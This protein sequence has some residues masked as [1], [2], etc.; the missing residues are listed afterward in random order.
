[1]LL[2][3]NL[4]KYLVQIAI[5]MVIG[6]FAWR[7]CIFGVGVR[8]EA[9]MRKKMF[10][11]SLKLSQRYYSENKTGAIMALYTNDLQT[12]RHYFG[13]GTIMLIDAVFLGILAFYK[14]FKLDLWLTVISV[15]PLLLLA[16]SG[17][18]VGKFMSRKFEERQK[19]FEN[20]SDFTLESFSGISVVKAFVKEAKELLRFRKINKENEEK[21]IEFAR[22]SVILSVSITLIINLVLLIIIGYGGYLVYSSK[23]DGTN[24]FTVGQL[25]EYISYFGT[26]TWPMMAISNLINMNAQAKAS[27]KRVTA[28]LDEKVE[29]KD[30]EIVLTENT[31]SDIV[32]N[33]L[34]FN[35]P[36]SNVKV[37]EDISFKIN[38]GEF[39]GVIGK[40]GSGKTTLVEMLLRVYNI[41][42]NSVFVGGVDIMKYGIKSLRSK[43][44][45]VPQDN[46]LFSTTILD[47][48]AFASEKAD[49]EKVKLAANNA[50]VLSNIEEFTEGFNTVLG[51]RGVTISGGQKQRT[52]IARALYKDPDILILDDSVS[53]CDTKTEA[54]ILENLMNLRKNKTTIITS[55]R[56][57]TV[58][59]LDK[60][61]LL[62][63]GK[64]VAYGTHD[65]LLDKCF[66]YKE[67]YDMQRLEEEVESYEG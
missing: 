49:F 36:D 13:M 59:S 34:S 40:T 67:M 28:L 15:I 65:E 63:D 23:I 21:N 14:M 51:E 31:S 1:M 26:L 10:E 60:I 9:D 47:N 37:L 24:S 5:I 53:A 54:T 17:G 42:N 46:F 3:K 57:S 45:Y 18:I 41:K 12:I 39:V 30:D 22:Y 25:Q 52:S 29:I 11:K 27:L 61:L 38:E 32:F 48:I 50:D 58:M 44:G 66:E 35:Y 62:D 8:I 6:R 19:A 64:I 43:I 33:N 20:M 56:I 7:I 55:H 4:M 16:L 2:V